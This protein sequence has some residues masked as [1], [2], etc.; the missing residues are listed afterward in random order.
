MNSKI[1]VSRDYDSRPSSLLSIIPPKSSELK[2]TLAS[3]ASEELTPLLPSFLDGKTP[4]NK[5]ITKLKK[6][7][8]MIPAAKLASDAASRGRALRPAHVFSRIPS[9]SIDGPSEEPEITWSVDDGVNETKYD[10]S[11]E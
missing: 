2:N 4:T 11:H 9:E 3:E 10:T 8:E 1:E 6:D 5:H 7:K